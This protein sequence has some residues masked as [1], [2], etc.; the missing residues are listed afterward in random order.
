MAFTVPI[1]MK[2]I[3]T[4]YIFADICHT[5]FDTNQKKHVESMVK[6]LFLLVYEAKL[7][8]YQFS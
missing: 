1:F 8:L 2:L 4:K 7:S 6:I 5:E 3:L